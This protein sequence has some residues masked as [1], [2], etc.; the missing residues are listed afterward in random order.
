MEKITLEEFVEYIKPY[1]SSYEFH[2]M[3]DTHAAP[4]PFKDIN[5]NKHVLQIKTHNMDSHVS[6]GEAYS[7]FSPYH[8]LGWNHNY[9]STLIKEQ[10]QLLTIRNKNFRIS[11]LE[12]RIKEI[13][14]D[15]DNMKKD[16]YS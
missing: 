1:F 4:H 6:F 2:R 13:F 14:D 16:H 3:E 15:L 9:L 12:H 7:N 10:E 11:E 8:T 5:Y